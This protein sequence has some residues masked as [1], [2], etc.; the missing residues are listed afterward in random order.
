MGKGGRGEGSSTISVISL[1]FSPKISYLSPANVN[2]GIY[3]SNTGMSMCAL[4]RD[5]LTCSGS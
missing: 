3:I 2:Y 1:S 5:V 4:P